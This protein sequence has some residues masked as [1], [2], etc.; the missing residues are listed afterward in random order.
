MAIGV[1]LYPLT[2][3]T[4]AASFPLVTDISKAEPLA[5][6]GQLYPADRAVLD[7]SPPALQQSEYSSSTRQ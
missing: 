5:D 7:R 3:V 2:V 6:V 4:P 1:D